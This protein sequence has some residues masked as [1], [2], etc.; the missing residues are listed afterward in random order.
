MF[1]AGKRFVY[2]GTQTWYIKVKNKLVTTFLVF[3]K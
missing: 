3:S 2:I 1:I